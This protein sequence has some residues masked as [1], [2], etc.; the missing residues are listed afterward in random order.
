EPESEPEPEPA[1]APMRPL[2]D[3]LSL[4][5]LEPAPRRRP[6]PARPA[7]QRRRP[8]PP[9]FR[10]SR[11]GR[12]T[13]AAVAAM[14]VVA[15]GGGAG[16]RQ[17]AP[18]LAAAGPGAG[19]L[20]GAAAAEQLVFSVSGDESTLASLRW[21][22]DGEDVTATASL[23]GGRS[24]LRGSHLPEGVHE[25][26][27][28]APGRIPGTSTRR[29]WTISIDRTPPEVVVDPATAKGMPMRPLTLK[30]RVEEGA[31][32][33]ANGSDV[34][35]GE[36]GIFELALAEPPAKPVAFVATD[37][38]GNTA[39]TEIAIELVPRRPRDP[40]RSVHVTFYAW[41]DDT[42]R[43][44]IMKLIDEGRINSVQLDLKDESGIIGWDADIPLG[45]QIGAVQDIMDLEAAVE[46]LHAKGIYVIG[47]IVA[48][49]DPIHAP[50]AWKRGWKN[51]VVQ[52][53]EGGM[54]GGYGG[55]T[56]FAN[57]VVRQ[58][59]IDVAKAAAAVGVDDILF[60]YIRRPDGPM[61]SMRFPQLAVKP[62][63]SIAAF[64]GEAREQLK[65]Y[66]VF[67]GA[68]VFGVA[69][70][71]PHEIAQDIPAMARNADYVAPMV[72]PSHW[73]PGE[74]GVANPNAQPYDITLASLKD[75]QEQVKGTGARVVPWLQDFTMGYTYG[76]AEVKAQIKAAADAGQPEWIMWDP[77]VT[78]TVEAYDPMPKPKPI[79]RKKVQP[80]P[81]APAPG[82]KPQAQPARQGA[83]APA[84]AA[85]AKV[86]ANELGLIPVLMYHQIRADGGGDYD[87]TPAQFRAELARLHREGYVPI[88]A[89]D[90][91]NGRIDVP[92][93][94]TPVVMTFDDSTKEQLA[95]DDRKRPKKDT[96]IAIMLEFAKQNPGFKPAGT[97]YV[98]RDPFAGD[99]RGVE[100]LRWLHENGFELGNHTYDHIPFNQLSGPAEI[101][102][103]LALGK[104]FI[105]ESV[106]G[107][108]VRTMALPLGVPP[109]PPGLARK[110]S[111]NGIDYAHAGVMLVGAEP[112]PSPFTKA[113]KPGAIP[114][115]RT[116]PP[117]ARDP[118]MGS[119]YW[120]DDLKA[121]PA[122]RYVSDGNPD[123]I[124]F[125]RAKA[126][127]LAPRF[128]PRAN[129]Y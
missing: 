115:I 91:A 70:S 78:Y 17:L 60:D 105:E 117:G 58:Y 108:K 95:W 47:R 125:P 50:A 61:S 129:P 32:L 25:I 110:G 77:L 36:G 15:V 4:D 96:A 100:M 124:S 81:A 2:A 126:E 112:A 79:V 46:E 19:A 41:K 73:G 62:E 8:K 63:E 49:R 106:P 113:F 76:P 55:F 127:S 52:T 123:T 85:A 6:R 30:G 98:N 116:T 24:L 119:T 59:N 68:S 56:N 109:D 43:A 93:G 83:A 45:K 13:V 122:K 21:T 16:L 10:L 33:K 94:K 84:A 42:L 89:V 101:Q 97:F 92:A 51:Q 11:P 57:P 23:V 120:L 99:P 39:T 114:R 12:R 37:S 75:F 20:I 64:L 14:A 74:Y 80:Q 54:Y 107:A 87:L 67:V 7:R 18:D 35:V 48:F 28:H 69:A 118:L 82:Q 66:D 102:K 9:A 27:A 38:H 1:A 86:R 103:Q 40:V 128:Q 5:L 104:R 121:N 90:L 72:Y 65:P 29:T 22:I 71:R 3:S 34:Q 111:W 44:G 88:R 31:E 26:V 53:P